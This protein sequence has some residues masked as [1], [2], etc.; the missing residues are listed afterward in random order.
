M[1]EIMCR[2]NPIPKLISIR[3]FLNGIKPCRDVERAIYSDSNVL[4]EIL[5]WSLDCQMTGVF[6]IMMIKSVLLR[7][8]LG[9]C[10]TS[11]AQ[12]PAKSASTNIPIERSLDGLIMRPWS[13][14]PIRYLT[15]CLSAPTSDFKFV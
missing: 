5:L 9:P 12:R 3:R 14:V 13:L 11:T 6:P 1:E 4:N 15:I 7:T 8:E 2:H 10:L